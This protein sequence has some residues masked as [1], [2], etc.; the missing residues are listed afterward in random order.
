MRAGLKR[1]VTQKNNG[2][3][4]QYS[5]LGR[6]SKT[7]SCRRE[8]KRKHIA[9]ADTD[10]EFAPI[11]VDRPAIVSPKFSQ[12][13]PLA[14][15]SEPARNFLIAACFT[16]DCSA[17]RWALSCSLEN[18]TMLI[19]LYIIVGVVL[20]LAGVV[21]MAFV[22]LIPTKKDVASLPKA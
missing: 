17:L 11:T 1:F 2:G 19:S 21:L 6:I 4:S 7:F 20:M 15:K 18:T 16:T 8:I 14:S 3:S 22:R 13:C 12:S 9:R 5:P 10:R